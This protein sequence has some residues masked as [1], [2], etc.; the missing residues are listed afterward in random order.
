MPTALEEGCTSCTRRRKRD[1]LKAAVNKALCHCSET[2][3][4]CWIYDPFSLKQC[5]GIGDGRRDSDDEMMHL[6]LL[7]MIQLQ[8]LLSNTKATMK[9][10]I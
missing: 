5:I 9:H 1:F 7:R 10:G 3:K 4:H 6:A 2:M 8:A